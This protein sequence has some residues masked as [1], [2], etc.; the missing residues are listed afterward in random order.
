MREEGAP[1]ISCK[2]NGCTQKRKK[3]GV[4]SAAAYQKEKESSEKKK[5][6]QFFDAG[7]SKGKK[8]ID[9]STTET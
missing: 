2:I 8:L 1:V 5:K 6:R 9:A 3:K 7:E 4:K